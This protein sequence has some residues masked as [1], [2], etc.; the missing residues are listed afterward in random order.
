MQDGI[1]RL[2]ERKDLDAVRCAAET[3]GIRFWDDVEANDGMLMGEALRQ[4][5]PKAP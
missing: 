3:H 4:R 5:R 2:S 1:D